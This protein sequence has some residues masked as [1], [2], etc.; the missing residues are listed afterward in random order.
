MYPGLQKYIL[1]VGWPAMTR[2]VL[3][4][5]SHI[6]NAS[7]LAYFY[8]IL[9]TLNDEYSYWSDGLAEKN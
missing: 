3:D 6:S 1:F 4:K 8:V 5:P 9:F 2:L 7:L